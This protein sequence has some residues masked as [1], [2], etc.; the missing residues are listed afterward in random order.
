MDD[1]IAIIEGSVALPRDVRLYGSVTGTLTVPRGYKCELFGTVGRDLVIER[2]ASAIVHGTVRGT[3]VNKGGNVVIE[4]STV[5]QINDHNPA[6][7][8][9][10]ALQSASSIINS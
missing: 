6:R 1:L 2:D 5:T 9:R 8:T 4:G 10:S 7:P 3:L